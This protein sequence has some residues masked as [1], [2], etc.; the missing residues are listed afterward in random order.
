MPVARHCWAVPITLQGNQEII[1]MNSMRRTLIILVLLPVSI[2]SGCEKAPRGNPVQAKDV[3]KD[4]QVHL[5][6]NRAEIAERLPDGLKLEDRIPRET[7]SGAKK[8]APGRDLCKTV[9]ETLIEAA[10]RIDEAGK[11]VDGEGR[12]I[13]FKIMVIG[14]KD[15][16]PRKDKDKAEKEK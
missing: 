3:G 14:G 10:A 13:V 4:K 6:A 12:D 11:L 1:G 8:L 2:C 9:E 7:G 5:L 15:R 16:G